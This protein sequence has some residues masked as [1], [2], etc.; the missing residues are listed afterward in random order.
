MTLTAV[1]ARP[2]EALDELARSIE[3]AKAGDRLAAVTVVVPTNTCGVMARRA[4]GRRVGI[5]G[6][7]M[8]TLNRLAELI[9][10]PVLAASGRSP[11]SSS[12]VE[13]AVAR[14]LEANPGSFRSVA[15]HPS[16]VVALRR[17]HDELRLAGPDAIDRLAL[18]STRAQEAVRI[19]RAVTAMLETDWYDEADLYRQATELLTSELIDRR[20]DGHR[21]GAGPG[22]TARPDRRPS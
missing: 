16:T 8:V 14:A 4:L 21:V 13:L 15:G 6:V 9:A 19:S 11:M 2:A 3:L 7:D 20:R 22:R 5:V 1:A 18:T 12:V 10:G 17:L